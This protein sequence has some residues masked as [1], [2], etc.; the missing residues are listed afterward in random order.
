MTKNLKFDMLMRDITNGSLTDKQD[1]LV[2]R[3][4]EVLEEEEMGTMDDMV[5]DI[6]DYLASKNKLDRYLNNEGVMQ[7]PMEM[8]FS[9]FSASIRKQ[10]DTD[11][12]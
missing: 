5:N 1:E 12:N 7:L 2:S 11:Q 4:E 9:W 3:M 10:N 6:R 8:I